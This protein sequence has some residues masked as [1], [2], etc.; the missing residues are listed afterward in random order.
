[1]VEL[2]WMMRNKCTMSMDS[3]RKQTAHPHVK[4]F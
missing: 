4:L 1:V 2:F 3:T